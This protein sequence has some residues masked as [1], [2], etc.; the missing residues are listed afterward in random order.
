MGEVC[1]EQ[2]VSDGYRGPDRRRQGLLG[3]LERATIGLVRSK[4]IA[5]LVTAF[6]VSWCFH[7]VEKHSDRK[8]E[9][10]QNVLKCTITQVGAAQ[11]LNGRHRVSVTPILE[12]CEKQ[13]GK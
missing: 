13:A 4:W 1:T 5:A 8:V 3:K 6:V 7:V 10:T 9:H 11:G 12:A 2:V